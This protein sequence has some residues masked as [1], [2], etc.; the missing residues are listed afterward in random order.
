MLVRLLHDVPDVQRFWPC[1]SAMGQSGAEIGHLV[2]TVPSRMGPPRWGLAGISAR[3]ENGQCIILRTCL[4]R[5]LS[6]ASVTPHLVA[7][8][9][10]LCPNSGTAVSKPY[11]PPLLLR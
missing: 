6:L 7:K 5:V 2:D 4:I 9:F 8:V 1:I 3:L 11:R 10:N